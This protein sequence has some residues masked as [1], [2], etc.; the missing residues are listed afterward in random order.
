MIYLNEE[1]LNQL[2]L[3]WIA[4]IKTIETAVDC[5]GKND[6]AQPI[7]PYLRYKDLKNRIIAMPAFV[8]GN[9]NMS[10]IKWIASFPD[11]IN[12]GIPRAHSVVILNNAA[13]GQPVGIINT[14]LLSII[15]TASV[16]GLM[17]KYYNEL[18]KLNNIN[19]GISG[20]GPIG[21]YHAKMCNEVLKDRIK[22]ISIFDIREFDRSLLPENAVTVNSWEEAYS[23]ADIFITCTVSK[24]S[25]INKLPKPGSL[26]L[27]VSLRD[28]TVDVY[29]FFKNSI[30]VDNWEEVCRE[31]TDVENLHLKKGLQEIDTKTIIDVVTKN[32]LKDYSN[33]L[34]IMFNPMGMGVFDISIGAYY[35]K[36]AENT[37]LGYKLN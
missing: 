18:K 23:N 29:D 5:L 33:E 6:F 3:N 34:P 28:Y 35:L 25:Y 30:I 11:N 1:S 19:I 24:A 7:K 22:K 13:T 37:Q 26:H 14:A 10:G 20:F 27:N 4:T 21:Q 8:G 32:C 2:G 36:L 9:I 17:I 12:K 15:R 16:S 31:N